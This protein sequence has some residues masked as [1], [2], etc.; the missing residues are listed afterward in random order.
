MMGGLDYKRCPNDTAKAKTAVVG[1]NPVTGAPIEIDIH[2]IAAVGALQ[3]AIFAVTAAMNAGVEEDFIERL[4]LAVLPQAQADPHS[5]CPIRTFIGL[6]DHLAVGLA[7]VVI[8]DDNRVRIVPTN[9]LLD[10]DEEEDD[11][12][13]RL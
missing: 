10:P 5:I 7:V 12:G 1:V 4:V 3:A 2:G 6:L 9:G 13:E 8:G 11:D